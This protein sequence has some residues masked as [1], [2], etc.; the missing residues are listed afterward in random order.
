MWQ[1]AIYKLVIFTAP[2]SPLAT[3]ICNKLTVIHI[4]RTDGVN[5]CRNV[6]EIPCISFA[7][8]VVFIITLFNT[9]VFRVPKCY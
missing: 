1:L 6:Y 8:I 7:L 3:K 2:F 4:H 5:I 9:L